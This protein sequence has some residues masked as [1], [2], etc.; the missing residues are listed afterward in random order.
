MAQRQIQR[1]VAFSL[2]LH[3][4]IY[5]RFKALIAEGQMRPG[6]RVPSLRGL[7][8][9]MG[10]ARGTVETAYDRL[11]GEGYLVARG[12]SGCYVAEKI[13]IQPPGTAEPTRGAVLPQTSALNLRPVPEP[14]PL[15]PGLPALDA[16]PR[17]LW[18][19]LVAREARAPHALQRPPV[20]GHAPLRRALAS[21]LYRARG[22]ACQAD[23]IFIVPGYGAGLTRLVDALLRPGDKA[24]VETPGFP[25]TRLVLGQLGLTTV[26]VPVDAD[27]IDVEAGR[28]ASLR[29]RL[30]VVT[31]AHQSP[32]G[33][34]MSLAR[35]AALLRWAH[36]QQSWI[37]EDD[38]DGEYRYFGRPLPALKSLDQSDRVIYAGTFSKV[39]FPGLRLAYLVVPTSQIPAFEASAFRDLNGGCPALMQAVVSEFIEQGHFARHIRRMRALYAKRRGYLVNALAAHTRNGLRVDLHEGGMHLIIGWEEQLHDDT[40]LAERARAVGFAVPA[41][42]PWGAGGKGSQGLLLSFTNVVTQEQ[43]IRL[44]GRLLR[45]LNQ[46][47]IEQRSAVDHHVRARTAQAGDRS[48]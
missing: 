46:T 39:L 10:V 40:V 30:A 41:L 37:L 31:P 17:K 48:R 32:L 5:E 18:A 14:S 45:A 29:A 28:R 1:G 15:T 27:G 36:E 6:Q 16:F 38:Y 33:V 7:A 9:E 13:S 2:P 3:A 44:V 22:I 11:I 24:W 26:P 35:R 42:S 23:Q 25:P 47:G 20:V 12:P 21:Y 19:R 8:D 43:A 34:S 4:Q